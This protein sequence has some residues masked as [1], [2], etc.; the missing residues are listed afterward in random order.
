MEEGN[1]FKYVCKMC[2]K[3]F[4][5]GRS[6]GGHMRSH[7][8]NSAETDEKFI[9]KKKKLEPDVSG[10]YILR[11][12]PK[13]KWSRLS[14]FGHIKCYSPD[15]SGFRSETKIRRRTTRRYN[16]VVPANPSSM[17][18]IEQEQQQEVALSLM[19][20]S[21]GTGQWAALDETCANSL[22]KTESSKRKFQCSGCNKDFVSHQALGG[23]RASHKR[24]NGGCTENSTRKL[25][26]EDE[27][28]HECPICFKVF[29]SG[30]ALGGHK[31]SHLLTD[32][33]PKIHEIP[34]FLDLNLPAPV[35]EDETSLQW[36]HWAH[37]KLDVT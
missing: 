24:I 12:K 30:Q 37:N 18:E 22:K 1:G 36:W 11:Q 23:H 7:M 9:N 16:E 26:E 10:G 13:K 35:D 33:S 14:L 19:M 34:E 27:T 8:N 5:C 15:N 17:S 29:T 21:R 31:R 32:A 4:P 25:V 2:P 3:S 28:R 6:L 20:L